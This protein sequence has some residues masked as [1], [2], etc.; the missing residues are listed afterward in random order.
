MNARGG[1][2]DP[3]A[4]AAEGWATGARRVYEPL[5]AD[6]VARAPHALAGRLVLDAGAGTG[7]GSASLAAVG[8][9]TVAMDRSAD[10]LSWERASRPPSVVGDVV[11]LP[12]A[13]GVVDD[14]LAGFV[15]NHLADPVAGLGELA[16][17]TRP[18]GALLASVFSNDSHSAARDRVDAAACSH[19]FGVPDWYVELKA[20]ATDLLGTAADVADAASASGWAAVDVVEN[21]VDV[22]VRTPADL[23][24]YRLGQAQF[25][26]WLASLSA[27]RRRSV[28]QSLIETVTPLDDPYRPIVISLVALRR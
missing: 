9:R 20:T 4:G 14:V 18:R 8:A 22:G 23:V 16:R 2:A 13:D 24:D 17:V 6:L 19:G 27:E 10:M 21:S 12:F 11:E 7:F 25:S 1:P 28:R 5:A 15:L 26:D 3:Y